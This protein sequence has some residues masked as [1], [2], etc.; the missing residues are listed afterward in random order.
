MRDSQARPC[1]ACGYDLRGTDARRCAECGQAAEV[2][3]AAWRA[4]AGDG[5][6]AAML[7]TGADW[8][9]AGY[10][11]I[12]LAAGIAVAIN[13]M[14]AVLRPDRVEAIIY[15]WANLGCL[16]AAYA[17]GLRAAF[18]FGRAGRP[19]GWL[20]RLA[21]ASFATALVAGGLAIVG[22]ILFESLGGPLPVP[23]EHVAVPTLATTVLGG[24][25][26]ACLTLW[27]AHAA[28]CRF[29][30][31]LLRPA[32]AFVAAWASVPLAVLVPF[33]AWIA[34]G[35]MAR[36]DEFVGPPQSIFWLMLAFGVVLLLCTVATCGLMLWLWSWSGRRLRTA[37]DAAEA[38][39]PAARRTVDSAGIDV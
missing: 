1:H 30:P 7:K 12:G 16:L 3:A 35:V 33:C 20:G 32:T 38:F 23:L 18:A 31:T 4:E 34:I 39:G 9:L 21:V 11:C 27:A 15:P 10:V 25:I 14:P 6:L 29:P 19:P 5:S 26:G 24:A 2:S 28:L 13:M 17:C 36:G 8:V 37:D 22:I